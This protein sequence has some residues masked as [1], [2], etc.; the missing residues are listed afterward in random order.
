MWM[1][2]SAPATAVVTDP[3]GW[4]SAP[5][6]EL[7][8]SAGARRSSLDRTVHSNECPDL[9]HLSVPVAAGTAVARP[10]KR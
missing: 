6:A 10:F 8:R 1:R 9:A 3:L 5:D 4:E 2:R 7:E